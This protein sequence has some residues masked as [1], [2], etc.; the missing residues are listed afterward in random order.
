MK[1]K[2]SRDYFRLLIHFAA[3]QPLLWL[4]WDFFHN[5]LTINPIQALEQR[6]GKYALF[7]LAA[8]LACTP[9]NTLFGFREA[10]RVR[11]ALGLYA[12]FYASLHFL[13]FTGLD[14]GF[15]WKLVYNEIFRRPYILIGLAALTI[16]L[17]LAATSFK[18]W[19]KRLGKN[20][21]RLHWLVYPAA[22]LVLIHFALA[23]KG[24]LLRLQGSISLSLTYSLVVLFL[25][26][27]RIP[28]IRKAARNLR[29][30]LVQILNKDWQAG[31][32]RGSVIR[33]EGESLGR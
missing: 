6:T 24:D 9:L 31:R 17:L 3:W 32:K 23:I 29:L 16:L 2:L 33:K 15:A 8:S 10:L 4:V 18:W 14:Y 26:I 28:K 5:K 11:R 19:M 20:W 30:R 13:I 1:K 12:F 25:L 7:F 27:V 22:V 21:K